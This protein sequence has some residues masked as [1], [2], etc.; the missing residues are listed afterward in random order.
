MPNS[1][2]SSKE[3]IRLLLCQVYWWGRLFRSEG[4]IW[5]FK[6]DCISGDEKQQAWKRF[7]CPGLKVTANM[8]ALRCEWAW[9]YWHFGYSS[10][11]SKNI[12]VITMT[13]EWGHPGTLWVR[14]G[15][16]TS[17]RSPWRMISVI[18]VITEIF[19]LH[20]IVAIVNITLLYI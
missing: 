5:P 6:G 16:L 19:L 12:S 17:S 20:S 2:E 14:P 11:C 13:W 18:I 15:V 9:C 7:Q 3:I 4:Q 1:E 8:K 10:P